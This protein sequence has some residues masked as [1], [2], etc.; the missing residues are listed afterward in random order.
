M[1]DPSP[2]AAVYTGVFDPVHFGHIDV[3]RRGSRLYDRFVVG[4]GIN[5]EK[6]TYFSLEERVELVRRLAAPLGN[7]EVR[8]FTGLAVQFV[9]EVGARVMF[10]GLRTLSDMEYEFSMSLTNRNLDPEIETVFL[11]AKED[12]SH[13]SSS[14]IRQVA[15]FGGALERFVPEEVKEA[16]LARVRQKQK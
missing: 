11:M 6:T 9:R 14:L 4:V 7:V 16:L 13:I 15:V 2:R 10:R 8:P 1:S 12:L 5:P 3:I